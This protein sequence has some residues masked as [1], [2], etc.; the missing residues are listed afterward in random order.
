MGEAGLSVN[1]L[2]KMV[3]GEQLNS[4][5]LQALME[6]QQLENCCNEAKRDADGAKRRKWR[7]MSFGGIAGGEVQGEE[8]EDTEQL[9]GAV[10]GDGPGGTRKR[11]SEEEVQTIEETAVEA[12]KRGAR[13]LAVQESRVVLFVPGIGIRPFH[14]PAGFEKTNSQ[15]DVY[16]STARDSVL[17]VLNGFNACLLC[18]GQTGSGKTYTMFGPPGVFERSNTVSPDCG[19]ALRAC[20][21][22]LNAAAGSAGTNVQMTISMQY[23]EIYNDTITDL[24][25]G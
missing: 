1:E 18:Y 14:F 22:L 23:V 12:K 11:K 4:E 24:L 7:K 19:V 10:D 3:E 13:V 2:E 8:S 9:P 21:E 16:E 5:V 20:D 6:A 15:R 17:S 25:S